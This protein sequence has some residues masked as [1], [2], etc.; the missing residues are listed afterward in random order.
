MNTKSL[1]ISLGFALLVPATAMAMQPGAPAAVQGR[2]AAQVKPPQ[3][4]APAKAAPVKGALKVQ[5]P[6]GGW[7]RPGGP[8][9]IVKPVAKPKAP[10]DGIGGGIPGNPDGDLKQPGEGAKSKVQPAGKPAKQ[11]AAPKEDLNKKRQYI[12]ANPNAPIQ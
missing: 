7:G 10:T 12:P 11:P 1:L 5:G 9:P 4:V 8:A 3:P 6:V 2:G